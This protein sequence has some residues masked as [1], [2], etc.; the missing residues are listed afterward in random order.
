MSYPQE[1]VDFLL[2]VWREQKAEGGFVALSTKDDASEKDSPWKD[3]T[4][5]F[6]GNLEP[7]LIEWFEKHRSK[8]K[9]FC[10]L[11]FSKP[12]RSKDLARD[13]IYL[14]SDIDSGDHKRCP[15]SILW[16]SSPGRFAGLWRL[17]KPLPPSEASEASKHLAYYIGGD[18]GGFDLTQVLR[19]PGT[20]N[21]KYSHRP[22]VKLV[23]FTDTILRKVP[24]DPLLKWRKVIP[25]KLLTLLEGPAEVGKR[26]EVLWNLWHELA[27]LG[28]PIEDVKV[29]L[30]ES[31]WNKYRGRNDEQ[32]R[33]SS[34]MEKI[35]GDRQEKNAEVSTELPLLNV[36][37][38]GSFMSKIP[39][40]P[41]WLVEH[42]WQR[43][44]HGIIAGQ[45]KSFKSTLAMDMALSV[46]SGK[47]FLET[48]EVH[49]EGPVL[50]IQNENTDAIVR[51][52]FEKIALSKG[53]VGRVEG[54]SKGLRIEWARD[55]PLFMVNQSGFTLDS[56]A[57]RVALESLIER[58][59]PN[60]VQ[61]DPLYLLF[62]GDIN[63]AQELNPILGWLLSLKQTYQ[64]AIQIVHHYN[65]SSAD[66]KRGGQRMLGS[67]TLHG[68]VESALY[69][70]TQ[71]PQEGKAIITLEREFRAAGGYGKAD[72]HISQG[73]YGDPQYLASFME[74]K[75]T[76][77]DFEQQIID[78]LATST[79]PLSKSSLS[80]KLGLSRRQIDKAVEVMVS[81]G[82]LILK[83][84]RYFLGD[85]SKC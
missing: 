59:K 4:F 62:A 55:L 58:L 16:E 6:D 64:C 81:K 37:S 48:F 52:R 57:N 8:D 32:E 72:I 71:D 47:P 19:I 56:E 83:G 78:A 44:S 61:L 43:A 12:R 25:R 36:E 9:Y 17:P 39:I 23:R 29:L 40:S 13:S 1:S 53:E 65:K 35:R 3:Y 15:P 11:T 5:P 30:M 85:L 27:D 45:P 74:H 34:E 26:S 68:W 18:R 79:E 60:L 66:G 22:E 54:D 69:L 33:F 70:E 73:P 42:W 24:Q 82:Y 84:E 7:K 51:D 38:Y 41:G 20:E 77:E 75:A 21:G 63:S 31:P 10:P 49:H 67:T 50:I 28:I 46:A 2:K 80:K 14:W 76:A